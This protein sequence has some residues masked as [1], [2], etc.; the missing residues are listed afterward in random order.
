MKQEIDQD[1]ELNRLDD[2][3][4]D[5]NPYRQLIVNNAEKVD[6]FLSQM[7]Q[8]LILSNVVNHIQC[9]RHPKIFYN[10][11]IP[12]VN[13][14]KHKRRSNMEEARQMLE[15]DFGDTPGKLKEEYLDIYNGIQSETLSTTR[16]D[17]N[18]DLSTTYLGRVDTT[19]DSKIRVEETF[20]ISDLYTVGKLLDGTECQILLDTGAIK[21]IISKSH[22]L[23]S[24][25]LH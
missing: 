20:P 25:S 10:L 13:K 12:A 2:T 7:E 11:S 21:S 3:S 16:F 5:I 4:G 9:N 14:E 23:C 17:G 15:L 8:W 19:R 6:T 24:K 18:S 1:Q 22:Y